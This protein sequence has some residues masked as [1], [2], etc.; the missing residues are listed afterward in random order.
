MLLVVNWRVNRP[1]PNMC[2]STSCWV[3]HRLLHHVCSYKSSIGLGPRDFFDEYTFFENEIPRTLWRPTP[4]L[5]VAAR[6]FEGA[7]P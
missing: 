3:W 7:L 6:E 2:V 5:R 4:T 1:C